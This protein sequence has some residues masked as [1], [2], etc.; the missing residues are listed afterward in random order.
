MANIV[1]YKGLGY[2]D[3]S[4]VP[5]LGQ[6][7]SR[8]KIPIEGYRIIVA[9]MSSIIGM[10]FLKEWIALP[11]EIRPLIHLQRDKNSIK[12][13][14]FLAENKMQDWVIVGIGLNTPEIE[15]TALDLG[16]KNILLDIAHGGLPGLD[17]V[18]NKLRAEF[19]ED[20]NLICGCVS[21]QEQVAYLDNI[22]WDTIRI[23]VGSGNAC[24][25]KYVAGVGIGAFTEVLNINSYFG[26]DEYRYVNVLADGG[27]YNICDFGKAFLAGA[28]FCMSGFV[29]T[30]CKNAQLHIDGTNEYYGMSSCKKGVR[31]GQ[32]KYDESLTKKISDNNLYS[33]YDILMKIWGGIRSAI[34]YSG[35]KSLEEAIGNGE[36]CILKTPMQNIDW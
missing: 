22:G 4:I 10:E 35:Y 27:F 23:G 3:V 33:L 34:S 13:L 25:T 8:T 5:S 14:N 6:V 1:N 19:G 7:E 2:N 26:N 31:G 32:T 15:K 11:Q 18:Y 36:F 9:G 17:K 30:K 28:D 16:Y 12:H 24:A 21:T 20:A 29:F